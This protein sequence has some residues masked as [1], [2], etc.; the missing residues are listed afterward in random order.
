MSVFLFTVRDPEGSIRRYK[1]VLQ[2][3]RGGMNK[4]AAYKKADVDRN[5]INN[6][7]AIAELRKVNREL[8]NDL[9]KNQYEPN[10]SLIDFA[11][12]CQGFCV[13]EP[14]LGLIEDL[15]KEGK[16]LTIYKR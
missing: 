4:S 16:L 13:V 6:Q 9:R 3:V 2:L 10:G 7:R 12:L 11:K 1:K 5:T 8:Y 14:Q 15:K